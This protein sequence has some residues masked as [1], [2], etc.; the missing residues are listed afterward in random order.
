MITKIFGIWRIIVEIFSSEWI[1]TRLKIPNGGPVIVLRC[2]LSAL[3]LFL[4][5]LGIL[6][7]IDPTKNWEFSMIELRTQIIDRYTIY[8]VL[9]AGM[10]TILYS[11]FSSQ[12]SYLANLYN[13]ITELKVTS[14]SGL[15][16][17]K[18][19]MW[20][21][22]FLEDADNLHLAC[23]G[24]YVAIILL[25]GEDKVVK[26]TFIRYSPGGEQRFNDLMKRAQESSDIVNLK[27]KRP[28]KRVQND[29]EPAAPASDS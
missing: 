28:N 5:I 8:A 2:I 26:D 22:A 18:L 29:G 9:F 7:L 12:W 25:W 14:N 3:L 27:F 19:S 23:K 6:N 16:D 13:K 4:L 10:Y 11:R 24:T 15:D 17:A 1:L 21:A 20:K